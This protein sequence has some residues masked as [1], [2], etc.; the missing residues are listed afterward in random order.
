MSKRIEVKF[1]DGK[2]FVD[3]GETFKGCTKFVQGINA[4]DD[5]IFTGMIAGKVKVHQSFSVLSD[6]VLAVSVVDWPTEISI[7][8][9]K[10]LM[11]VINSART[12]VHGNVPYILVNE[13][14]DFVLY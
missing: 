7:Q 9:P 8:V 14:S 10:M 11:P 4:S 6:V 5:T 2:A 1:S 13:P 3:M 12:F